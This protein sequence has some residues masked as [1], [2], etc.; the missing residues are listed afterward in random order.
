[1]RN[2]GQ[3]IVRGVRIGRP[4]VWMD[5]SDR[6]F[7]ASLKRPFACLVRVFSQFGLGRRSNPEL[8]LKEQALMR[9]SK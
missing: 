5:Q 4:G 2:R 6:G 1:M 3:N 7:P 9:F 8:H